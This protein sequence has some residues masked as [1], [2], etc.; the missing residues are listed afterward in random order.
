ML[1]EFFRSGVLR[2]NS[3]TASLRRPASPSSP[4]RCLRTKSACLPNHHSFARP[5]FTYPP[6]SSGLTS[7]LPKEQQS[8]DSTVA[9]NANSPRNTIPFEQRR[10]CSYQRSMC[11]QS[12]ATDAPASNVDVSKGREVLPK[13]VKPT[14]YHLTLEPNLETFEFNGHVEIEYVQSVNQ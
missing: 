13:N 4:L 11:R 5:I 9:Q 10:Y 3:V 7:F 12:L 6:Q 8:S 1:V 14:H 2:P